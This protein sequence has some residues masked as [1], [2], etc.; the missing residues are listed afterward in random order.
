VKQVA[1]K[2]PPVRRVTSNGTVVNRISSVKNYKGKKTHINLYGKNGTGKTTLACTF[3]KPLLIVGFEDGIESVKNVTGVDFVLVKKT[4]ELP[5]LAEYLVGSKYATVV[6]DTA[7]SLQEMVLTEILGLNELPVQLEWGTAT[8]DQY[9]KRS[10]KTRAMLK[11]FLGL[12]DLNVVVI[13]KE[14]DHNQDSA[15]DSELI[16]PFIASE[17]GGATCG[18]LGDACDF[19]CQTFIRQKTVTTTVKIGGKTT[20]TKRATDEVEYCLRM[21]AHP[22]YASRIR[23]VRGIDVPREIVDPTYDKF[24]G[25]IE[26]KGGV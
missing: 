4:D 18:W 2:R 19:I 14:K 23:V 22:I 3:P 11:L 17:L 6:L 24:I 10:E 20:K 13:A 15:Q 5:A 12:T 21:L 9:R 8:L 1:K 26:P 25:A 7:T 16:Q